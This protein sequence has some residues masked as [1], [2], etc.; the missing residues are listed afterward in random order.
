MLRHLQCQSRSSAA[1][2]TYVV[3]SAELGRSLVQAGVGSED[4]PA[5]FTLVPDNPSHGDGVVLEGG[6]DDWV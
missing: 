5:A 2:A 1:A 6:V 4:R 3:E